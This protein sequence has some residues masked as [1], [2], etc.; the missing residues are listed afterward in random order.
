[1]LAKIVFSQSKHDYTSSNPVYFKQIESC[2]MATCPVTTMQQ[3]HITSC[4]FAFFHIY[5]LKE[6]ELID[7]FF[8]FFAKYFSRL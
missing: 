4:T 5:C 8:F 6:H 1:M 3:I 7:F 2:K